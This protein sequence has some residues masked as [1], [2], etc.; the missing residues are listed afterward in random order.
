MGFSNNFLFKIGSHVV[1]SLSLQ[2]SVKMLRRLDGVPG[3]CGIYL[4][5]A[6]IGFV[7]VRSTSSRIT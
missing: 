5:S 3:F 7:L 1:L 6:G 4:V 2:L